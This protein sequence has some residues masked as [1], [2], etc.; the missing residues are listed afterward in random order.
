MGKKSKSLDLKSQNLEKKKLDQKPQK[1]SKKQTSFELPEIDLKGMLEAGCH[2]GH[3]VAKTHP[4]IKPYLYGARNGIQIFDLIQTAEQL[5]K[6]GDFVARFV[7]KGGKI[8]FI[9]TKRQARELIKKAAQECGM[10]Y[11]TDRWLGGTITNWQQIQQRIEHLKELKENFQKGSYKKKPKKE[12][13]IVKREIAR[14][15]RNFGGLRGLD[16]LP[17]CLLVVDIIREKTAVEEARKKSV[18]VVAIVDSNANPDL[19]DYPIPANDD[20]KKSIG[21]ILDWISQ[22]VKNSFSGKKEGGE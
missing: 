8:V 1:R 9:G 6:A 2:F 10:P 3:R 19:V 21:Y 15:E 13:A 7:S 12:Q 16:S 20:A 5:K 11:V 22:V 18:P 17:G 4:K 14:L